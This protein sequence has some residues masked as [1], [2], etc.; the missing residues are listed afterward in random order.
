[1]S[2]PR[3]SG[4]YPGYEA[5][6]KMAVVIDINQFFASKAR[7]DSFEEQ[8]NKKSKICGYLAANCPGGGS[9]GQHS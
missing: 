6:R 9:E 3:Q 7:D 4:S 5:T 1:M 8:E 2:I